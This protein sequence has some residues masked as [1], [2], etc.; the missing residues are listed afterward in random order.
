MSNIITD[1]TPKCM[2]FFCYITINAAR[3]H[4]LLAPVNMALTWLS[5]ATDS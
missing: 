1:E 5:S 2:C 4:D 3:S